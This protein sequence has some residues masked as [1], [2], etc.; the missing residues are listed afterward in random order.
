MIRILFVDED[1]NVMNG[2]HRAMRCLRAQWDTR[3]A[4]PGMDEE[5]FGAPERLKPS[6]Q[7]QECIL[8]AIRAT[9]GAAR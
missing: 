1:A 5:C 4:L 2:L 8:P 7:W 6:Q 9:A 3:F